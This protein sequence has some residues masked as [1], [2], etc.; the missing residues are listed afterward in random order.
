MGDTTAIAW[1]DK[2]W[3]PWQGCHKV[4]AGCANCY[5]H[6]EKKRYGQ[7]P[8]TVV[9]SKPAT[10]NAP[11]KWRDP[12][13][14]FTCSWS[15]FFIEEADDWRDEAME[16]VMSTGH[17][18][19]QI[20]TKRPE[21]LETQWVIA[22]SNV[23]LGV[24]VEDQRAADERTAPLVAALGQHKFLSCE[25]LLGPVS[26]DLAGIGW[27][28]VGGESGPGARP[29][30]PEWARSIRDQCQAAGVPFFFKQWGEWAPFMDDE[31]Y[32][33]GGAETAA[34]SQTWLHPSGESGLCWI[35]DGD[36]TWSNHTGGP[37]EDGRVAIMN[38]WGKARAGRLLDGRQWDEMP[39]VNH[40]R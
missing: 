9:R 22:P 3:N 1:T 8:S 18:T 19:Y 24:T 15:D 40:A 14:V 21:R 39:E 5:M 2:T 38:R 34:K 37:P 4:S 6:R 16:I 31:K 30:H 25:P 35:M 32:T 23:W 29:M 10:F 17:L 11:L 12:A 20:L 36:G 13:L 26:L 7:D 33:Y 27:V 28:I